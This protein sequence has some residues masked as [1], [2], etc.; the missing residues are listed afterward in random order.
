VRLGSAQIYESRKDAG[1]YVLSKERLLPTEEEHQLY[2][3]QC[4]QRQKQNND[5][6]LRLLH[7]ADHSA[8]EGMCS[9]VHQMRVY[10][11]YYLNNLRQKLE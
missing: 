4:L 11:E 1:C 10:F 5:N 3:H 7:V 8:S 9:N 2:H 6:I